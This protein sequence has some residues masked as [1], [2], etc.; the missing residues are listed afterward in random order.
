MPGFA[1]R[2]TPH[3][4]LIADRQDDTPE[5]DAKAAARL[6]DAFVRGTGHGL[7]RLGAGEVGQALPPVLVWWR[8]FAARYIGSLCLNASGAEN[9]GA[10]TLPDVPAPT[11]AECA[12]LVLTAPVMAGAEYLTPD[13]LLG[14]VGGDRTG[15]RRLPGRI[16][17][18]PAA[19]SHR[20][21][22][23][24]EP[25]RAVHF[26]LAEN[27]RDAEQPFAFMATYTT[28]LSAQAKAQQ[29]PLGQ[30]LR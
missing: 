22:S 4:H 14:F 20:A 19:L 1:L 21:K 25:R 27:R 28:R 12:S 17:H 26:N 6:T 23:R 10:A 8:A 11:E 15:F 3:G 30:A 16:R 13:V 7:V 18:G 5:I 9:D 29:V 2:P 24:L